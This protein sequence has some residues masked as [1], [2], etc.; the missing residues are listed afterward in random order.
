MA[1]I[2]NSPVYKS[3]MRGTVYLLNFIFAL[4]SATVGYFGAN[5][6]SFF[7]LPDRYIA[8]VFALVSIFAVLT[9]FFASKLF[10]R[11]GAYRIVFI[12]AFL[13][14]F[15]YIAQAYLTDIRFIVPV[16]V[17]GAVPAALLVAAFD[18]LMERFTGKEEDTGS[19]RG[20]FITLASA[21]FVTGP[22]IGGLLVKGNDF[23]S[24]WLA[25]SAFLISLMILSF[26]KLK[27]IERI[28]YKEFH[29][30]DTIRAV[31]ADK[32]IFNIFM[33]QFAL[34]FFFS[35][36]VIYTSVYLR[37]V[38]D[39]PYDVIGF[40]FAFMLLPFTFMTLPLGRLADK[41]YG[42]KEILILGLIVMAFFTALFGIS[43]S[44]SVFVLAGILFGTRVGAAAAQS[45]SETYF[46]KMVDGKD[47]DL[48]SAFRAMYPLAS[49]IAPLTASPI[50]FFASFRELFLFL[51]IVVLSGV[52]FAAK[53]EDTK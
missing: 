51:A 17:L 24:L 15:T 53:I 6:L 29:I 37:D 45:M 28:K 10:N 39:I 14:L 19:Q 8:F 40:I 4:Q 33:A 2:P 9:F 3:R 34:Y 49:I 23:R 35:I 42:E 21:A 22:F 16:F 36:M 1:T 41:K 44:S 20:L 31:L 38:L 30:I 52:Y 7:G 46:F 12:S 11:F 5:Y 43:T 13:Y 18:S 50:L 47:T 27:R 48:I 26:F 32:N 25:G